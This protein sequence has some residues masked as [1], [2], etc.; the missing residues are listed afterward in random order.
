MIQETFKWEIVT[1]I[2]IFVLLLS[3][4]VSYKVYK[5]KDCLKVGHS[6]FYCI[7]EIGSR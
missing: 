6:K 1:I 3:L 7:M 4:G 2:S 5:Y